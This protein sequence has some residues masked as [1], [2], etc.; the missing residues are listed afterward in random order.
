MATG[1]VR[2][3][4]SSVIEKTPSKCARS[5]EVRQWAQHILDKAC[6]GEA[7][8]EWFDNFCAEMVKHLQAM[9]PPIASKYKLQSP[10]REHLWRENFKWNV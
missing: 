4:L 8:I 2:G 5:C 9:I 1:I 10:K 6:Q 3:A 7:E